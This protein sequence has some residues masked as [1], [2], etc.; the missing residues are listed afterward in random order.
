MPALLLYVDLVTF[1]TEAPFRVDGR[2]TAYPFT[3]LELGGQNAP[4]FFSK[5]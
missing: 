3:Y 1:S 5:I 2:E 4:P